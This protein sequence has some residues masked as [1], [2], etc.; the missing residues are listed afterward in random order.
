M[1]HLIV[2]VVAA[3][4]YTAEHGNAAVTVACLSVRHYKHSKESRQRDVF[5]GFL[6]IGRNEERDTEGDG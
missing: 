4:I 6:F 3:S 5:L 2:T 1:L